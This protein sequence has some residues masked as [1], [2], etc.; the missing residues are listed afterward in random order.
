MT[1]AIFATGPALLIFG[2]KGMA[3]CGDQN[4]GG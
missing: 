4:A 3:G 1:G 2:M